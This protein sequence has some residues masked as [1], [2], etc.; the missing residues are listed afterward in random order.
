MVADDTLPLQTAES[1]LGDF[2]VFLRRVAT[3]ENVQVKMATPKWTSLL[4]RITGHQ[5]TGEESHG[6][7][8]LFSM[9]VAL[10]LYC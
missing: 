1:C 5:K 8:S 10:C 3:S 4:L 6:C 2:L 7:T 9:H